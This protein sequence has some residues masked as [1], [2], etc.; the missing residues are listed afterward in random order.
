MKKI[1]IFLLIVLSMNNFSKT[2]HLNNKKNKI[3]HHKIKKY[4]RNR[5]YKRIKNKK[6]IIL[7][8]TEG[9]VPN[10]LFFENKNNEIKNNTKQQKIFKNRKIQLENKKQKLEI[11]NW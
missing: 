11:E 6:E 8:S 2:K 10:I 5:K 3:K 9:D 4:K 1:L 7:I